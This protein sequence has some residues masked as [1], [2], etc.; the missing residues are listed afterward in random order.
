MSISAIRPPYNTNV[1]SRELFD[2][3]VKLYQGYVEKTNEIT[4]K[5]ANVQAKTLT[6]ANATYSEYRGLKRGESFALDGV[7]LHEYYFQDLGTGDESPGNRTIEL[8]NRY[9]GNLENWKNTFIA[10]AKT[11]RGWCILAFEQRTQ[12]LRNITLDSH[13]DGLVCGAFPLLVLDVYEHAYTTDY[14]IDKP[15]YIQN[16]MAA[17]NWDMV[18]RRAQMLKIS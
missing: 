17:I 7:I 9:F 2:N 15:T 12:S 8:I 10:S 18:E 13:D 6:D 14:G 4:N 16:F 1:V 3:H 5:L 11:A